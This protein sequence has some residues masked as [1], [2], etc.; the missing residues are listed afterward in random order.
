M[1]VFVWWTR[2]FVSKGNVMT[3]EALASAMDIYMDGKVERAV[4]VVQR[5]L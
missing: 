4:H 5:P 2:A 3:R 1:L